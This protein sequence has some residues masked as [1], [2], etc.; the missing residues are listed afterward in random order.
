M[1]KVIDFY[2][3]G[4]YKPRRQW[5]PAELRGKLL[6]FPVAKAP[7][8]DMYEWLASAALWPLQPWTALES[9]QKPKPASATPSDRGIAGA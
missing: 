2:F 3:P 7:K 5:T 9:T 8:R 4:K 1:A 6:G